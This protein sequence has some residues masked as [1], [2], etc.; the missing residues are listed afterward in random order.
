MYKKPANSI[1][2]KYDKFA[3]TRIGTPVAKFI[4]GFKDG[5]KTIYKDVRK[6]LK[7]LWGKIKGVK[8]ETYEKAVVNTVGTSGGIASGVTALKET[9]EKNKN[10]EIDNGEK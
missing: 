5:I 4:D 2:R 6:G 1:N 3:K 8:K 7:H 9:Q 10:S